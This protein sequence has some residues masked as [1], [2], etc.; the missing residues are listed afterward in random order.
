MIMSRDK[1]PASNRQTS[2]REGGRRAGTENVLHIAGLGAACALAERESSVLPS[3]L[4]AMRDELQRTLTRE[5]G[6][7][8]GAGVRVNGPEVGAPPPHEL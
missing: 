1:S 4:A 7:E 6:G 3:H 5:L 2:I 8:D